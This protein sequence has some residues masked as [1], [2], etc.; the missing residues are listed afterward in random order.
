MLL[1]AS[2]RSKLRV[3]DVVQRNWFKSGQNSAAQVALVRAQRVA[4]V[5]LAQNL[6]ALWSNVRDSE[7]VERVV[8]VDDV[9]RRPIGHARHDQSGQLAK[10]P[11]SIDRGGK[12]LSGQSQNVARSLVVARLG[13]VA[14]EPNAAL[15]GA[16]FVC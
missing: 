8:L 1:V 9:H 4:V 16:G 10:R 11:I 12:Q 7:T 5:Q 13:D 2:Q 15:G 14:E 6:S 3:V